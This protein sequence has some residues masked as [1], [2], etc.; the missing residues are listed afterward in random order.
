MK[1][2]PLFFEPCTDTLFEGRVPFLKYIWMCYFCLYL[3]R[4]LTA[5]QLMTIIGFSEPDKSER[6]YT[7]I[8]GKLYRVCCLHFFCAK[9]SSPPHD[10]DRHSNPA[11]QCH[12]WCCST[13]LS[14]WVH[15]SQDQGELMPALVDVAI[16]ITEVWERQ[17][18]HPDFTGRKICHSDHSSSLEAMQYQKRPKRG[19]IVAPSPI[20]LHPSNAVSFFCLFFVFF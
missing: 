12:R 10:T 6:F 19:N 7:F 2:R 11:A 9:R 3:R 5:L 8:C 20:T 15:G 13:C 16:S 1:L 17:K 4:L 14:I 18:D